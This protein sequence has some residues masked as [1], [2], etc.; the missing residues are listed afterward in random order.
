MVSFR[1]IS[2]EKGERM[3]D[4]IYSSSALSAYHILS[5]FGCLKILICVMEKHYPFSSLKG[6][7]ENL[8]NMYMNL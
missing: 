8:I 6:W 7:L 5:P 3:M 4:S 2:L 1:Q